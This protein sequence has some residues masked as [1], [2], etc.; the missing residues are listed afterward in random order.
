MNLTLDSIKSKILPILKNSGVLRAS[1]F[2]SVARGDDKA[3]SDIDLL[4]ELPKGKS[5]F[6]LVDLKLNLEETT[7]KKFDVLTFNSIHPLLR[8]IIEREQIVIL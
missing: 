7:R 2:G 3:D 1:L 6:D 4:V 5:L 8:D